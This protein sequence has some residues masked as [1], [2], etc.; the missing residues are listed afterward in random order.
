[1][2]QVNNNNNN[3]SD[4][5]TT[6][7]N[8]NN[9]TNNEDTIK[10]LELEL[11]KTKIEE[12]NYKLEEQVEAMLNQSDRVLA[13]FETI[14]N[15]EAIPNA[16]A[17]EVATILGWK[18]IVKKGL[19]KVNDM[20]VYVE[21]DSILP[22]WDYFI[23]DGLDKRN[24]RIKTIK[25]RGQISAG[26]CIPIREL[27]KHPHKTLEFNYHNNNNDNIN[28]NDHSNIKEIID[29][30][31]NDK[32]I[33]LQIGI[34]LTDFIGIKKYVEFVY[35]PRGGNRLRSPNM[36]LIPFPVFL[37]KTDQTRIQNLSRFI[38]Q[39]ADIE[40]EIT[41]KLEGSSITVYH[42]NGKSGICSRNFQLVDLTFQMEH[43]LIQ[44]LDILSKITNSKENIALQGEII[45]P[46]IQGNIYNLPK[47]MYRVFDIWLIE[48]Q[49]YATFQERIDL[50][51]KLG[52][53][54]SKHGVPVYNN[55]FKFDPN[56]NVDSL[57]KLADGFS[58]LKESKAKVLREGLVFK[59]K[60]LIGGGDPHVLS[61][62]V[63]SNEYLIKKK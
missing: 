11:K 42:F 26:Y 27:I 16:D 17:I 37:K 50:M 62:K 47:A 61:F 40:F 44:D 22:S 48:K 51:D 21:I 53:P 23:N 10:N 8:N 43:A 36:N 30:S 4:T 58:L 33:P 49:R 31:D 56:M 12:E 7:N 1:M 5:N 46:G 35:Q 57:L 2:I 3:T 25:L 41:E 63:I 54:W 6:S 32:V 39:Y 45:G 38:T 19:Y 14:S 15:L 28:D 52:I 9:I 55:S 34:D 29:K 60:S 24:F 18:V 59:S 20:V 13:Y